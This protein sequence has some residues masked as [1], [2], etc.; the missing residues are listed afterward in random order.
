M[1][2]IAASTSQITV[3]TYPICDNRTMSQET[4]L[5]ILYISLIVEV[6]EKFSHRPRV[7]ESKQVAP[8]ISKLTND[9]VIGEPC[10]RSR[11]NQRC[12]LTWYHENV[13][14]TSKAIKVLVFRLVF[15][16]MTRVETAALHPTLQ[17]TRNL[18]LINPFDCGLHV[19][20][21]LL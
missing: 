15:H 12:E 18:N 1:Q 16:T 8:H 7:C 20:L 6:C 17:T 19:I 10:T 4:F 5:K 13:S 14:Q 9:R 11:A 21:M 2:R 3:I